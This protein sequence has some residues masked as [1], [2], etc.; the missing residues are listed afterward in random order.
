MGES[1]AQGLLEVHIQEDLLSF[2]PGYLSKG[3]HKQGIQMEA[4]I[5]KVRVVPGLEEC[6]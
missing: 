1:R 5:Y 4:S 6:P 3:G 2:K